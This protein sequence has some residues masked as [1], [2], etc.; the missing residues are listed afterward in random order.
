MGNSAL[1]N[2]AV[3]SLKAVIKPAINDFKHAKC[4]WDDD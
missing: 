2:T 4:K 3:P 1:M